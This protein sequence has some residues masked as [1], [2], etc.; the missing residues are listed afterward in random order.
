MVRE[1]SEKLIIRKIDSS[2]QN[3]KEKRSRGLY[4]DLDKLSELMRL[5]EGCSVVARKEDVERYYK[6]DPTC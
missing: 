2:K 5:L 4:E 6:I 3:P 1:H